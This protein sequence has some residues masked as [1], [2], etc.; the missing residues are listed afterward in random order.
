MI[1]D[2]QMKIHPTYSHKNLSQSF[3]MVVF[4]TE[5][6]RAEARKQ[7]LFMGQPQDFDV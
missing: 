2:L 3:M 6:W 4:T 1:P 5:V 7:W